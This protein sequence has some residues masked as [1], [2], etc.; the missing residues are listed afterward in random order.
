MQCPRCGKGKLL[1]KWI[2]FREQC[3]HCQLSFATSPG[4]LWGTLLILDRVFLFGMIV[5]I[6]F[7]LGPKDLVTH[8]VFYSTVLI[9]FVVTFPMRQALCFAIDY[10][11]RIWFEH[12]K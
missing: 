6:Y 9:V 10:L 12:S 8:F 5:I 7:Q 3:S 1:I 2:K 11:F 4:D